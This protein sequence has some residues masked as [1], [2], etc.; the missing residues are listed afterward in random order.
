[1]TREGRVSSQDQ[2]INSNGQGSS[3]IILV[4]QLSSLN[5]LLKGLV[6]LPFMN[7]F[8][9]DL[10]EVKV[11][12]RYF[13]SSSTSFSKWINQTIPIE[14]DN[15]LDRPIVRI[16][17]VTT[18]NGE[19][20]INANEGKQKVFFVKEDHKITFEGISFFHHDSF[21]SASSGGGFPS[22]SSLNNSFYPNYNAIDYD[23]D[24]KKQINDS[25]LQVRITAKHGQ[26]MLL[27]TTNLLIL[28]EVTSKESIP[29]IS[30][31]SSNNPLNYLYHVNPLSF[32]EPAWRNSVSSQAIP[33]SLPDAFT[34]S[35]LPTVIGTPYLKLQ[36]FTEKGCDL[37]RLSSVKHFS[38]NTCV[39]YRRSDDN[40]LHSSSGTNNQV[41]ALFVISKIE[42]ISSNSFSKRDY[43]YNT[44]TCSVSSYLGQAA[45]ILPYQQ[46]FQ[47]KRG[48]NSYGFL[49]I[50]GINSEDDLTR[51]TFTD[52][53]Q[54]LWRKE[55]LLQGSLF[56]LNHAISLLTY[57]PNLNWNSRYNRYDT[58]ADSK[59]GEKQSVAYTLFCQFNNQSEYCLSSSTATVRDQ[60]DEL[61]IDIRTA[62]ST[63][64]ELGLGL[65]LN[66]SASLFIYVEAVNDNPV[67]TMPAQEIYNELGLVTEDQLSLVVEKIVPFVTNED[68]L[69]FLP[70]LVIRD[71]DFFDFGFLAV[72]ITVHH[73]GILFTKNSSEIFSSLFDYLSQTNLQYL[74]D[75]TS[76]SFRGIKQHGL[77]S[78][79]FIGRIN[80]I[81][82][83]FSSMFFLPEENYW[84]LNG[85]IYITI[86]DL[87]NYGL[88]VYDQGKY[89]LGKGKKDSIIIPFIIHPVNDNPTVITPAENSGK[90]IFLLDEGSIL[91]L[92]G[93]SHSLVP[94]TTIQMLNSAKANAFKSGYEV[95]RL[96]EPKNAKSEAT[97][98][99]APNSSMEF[100]YGNG[101]LD[102]NLN[103]ISDINAGPSS[104][105]P[106]FY[107]VYRNSM[108]YQAND[109]LHGAELWRD[110]GILEYDN[111]ID[112]FPL[113]PHSLPN[114]GKTASQLF[115]DLFPG[116]EASSPSYL[117]VH[118]DILY[119]SAN[120]I[121]TSWMVLPEHR[122]TCS[123]FRQS[124]FDSRIFYGV[125][126]NTLWQPGR[127]Y[128]CPKGYRWMSTD[129]A[130]ELFTLNLQ[131]GSNRLWHSEAFSSKNHER[132]GNQYYDFRTL[133]TA[134]SVE[135]DHYEKVYFSQCGWNG[136]KYWNESRIHFRFSD[137]HL[138][139]AYKHTASPDPFHPDYDSSTSMNSRKSL[140][141]DE[142]A[143]IVCVVD[144]WQPLKEV[145]ASTAS[146][147]ALKNK[148]AKKN[149]VPLAASDPA[150]LAAP[151]YLLDRSSVGHELW[152]SDGSLEGT[153][154][155]SDIYPGSQS[156]SPAYLTSFVDGYLYFAATDNEEGRELWRSKG[157]INDAEIVSSDYQSI[158]MSKGG[159]K[160]G[161][162]GR[163]KENRNGIYPGPQSSSPSDIIVVERSLVFAATDFYHGREVVLYS[164][165]YALPTPTGINNNFPGYSTKDI[166]SGFD[167]S[168]PNGFAATLDS[169]NNP[170]FPV[171][172]QARNNTIGAE[173]WILS[174]IDAQPSLVMNICPGSGSSNPRY[175]TYYRQKTLFLFQADDCFFGT[176]LWRSDGTT[177]GTY[178]LKDISPGTF[179]S[180]PSYLTIMTSTLDSLKDFLYFSANDRSQMSSFRS[181][182]LDGRVTDHDV[183]NEI[184][185]WRTDGTTE[186]T[187]RA[188]DRSGNDFSLDRSSLD[189]AFPAKFGIF[190]KNQ[191]YVSASYGDYDT[192]LPSGG[193]NFSSSM[194]TSSDFPLSAYDR[195]Q[196]A[197]LDDIDTS[198]L[199]KNYTMT[200]SVDKGILILRDNDFASSTNI[201]SPFGRRNSPVSLKIL[202]LEIKTIDRIY[203]MNSLV[204]LGHSVD[205]FEESDLAI[206]AIQQAYHLSQTKTPSAIDR[207]RP[208]DALIVGL[209]IGNDG[210][211]GQYDGFQV[212]RLIRFW[213]SSILLNNPSYSMISIIAMSKQFEVLND[214]SE[215]LAAGADLFILQPSTEYQNSTSFV[216][217]NAAASSIPPSPS[218]LVINNENKRISFELYEK[219]IQQQDYLKL[220][221]YVSSFLSH[222]YQ[223]LNITTFI[224]PF[225][226][227]AINTLSS[228]SPLFP[229]NI[230]GYKMI[231]QGN[232]TILND[233]LMNIFFYS[234]NGTNAVEDIN[235][236]I[237]VSDDTTPR[238]PSINPYELMKN[239]SATSLP[240]S[241]DENV[242]G[243]NMMPYL[244][245]Y[246]DANGRI[247]NSSSSTFSA[248]SDSF[249]SASVSRPFIL[250]TTA[251]G[252]HNIYYHHR[253]VV[254]Y[255]KDS[256]LNASTFGKYQN[257]VEEDYERVPSTK[258]I[259]PI[260]VM[261]VNQ[262]P[263]LQLLDYPSV[264]VTS[265]YPPSPNNPNP[266][267]YI[268]FKSTLDEGR[269]LPAMILSDDDI[270]R[271]SLFN[272]YGRSIQPSFYFSIEAF[273]GRLT[274]FSELAIGIK[275][276]IGTSNNDRK[277]VFQGPLDLLQKTFHSSSFAVPPTISVLSSSSS[278]SSFSSSN[279]SAFQYVCRSIDGCQEGF[280]DIITIELNDLGIYGKGG[281]ISTIIHLHMNITGIVHSLP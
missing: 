74:S 192:L 17:N 191:L 280:I 167:S 14:V 83:L 245:D 218:F 97:K 71:V 59:E 230:F 262:P 44:S 67:I 253:N 76:S 198:P 146:M 150:M 85:R 39:R 66:D 107:T 55:I 165:P 27:T 166:V 263:V 18:S 69:L 45:V 35:E 204:A 68:E 275:Q 231:L 135:N 151:S 141:V 118:N 188:F 194:N 121:D 186:G 160:E 178:M 152:R 271:I 232:L 249:S 88:G 28:N 112:L 91:H 182:S 65:G 33:S 261:A 193:L 220:G 219:E 41:N 278:S 20:M 233:V 156:S 177:A 256:F 62:E 103:T 237:E 61:I 184:Q 273:Y 257:C 234:P 87:G 36:I 125:T 24:M 108:Y 106:R 183:M 113:Y 95:W 70:P 216:G 25:I 21:L 133:D 164:Y 122:D 222:F 149:V 12:D 77:S 163:E 181:R 92:L 236:T 258:K 279:M 26:F 42:S 7:Y 64:P 229:G 172:F 158:G 268:S 196:L 179:G 139:G 180:F 148:K 29:D 6:Y 176:E 199:A 63:L 109:G 5:K 49:S 19:Y 195:R 58:R 174:S 243:N 84:G 115:L 211:S 120:G 187:Q 252:N 189:S 226:E 9:E 132:Q 138:T 212:I 239:F 2:L 197:I 201:H 208:Y 10:L 13:T 255:I 248:S 11:Q 171:L 266:P 242:A 221:R 246:L 276:S 136:V 144:S 34:S 241:H 15:V 265:S 80:I 238:C 123:S 117:T 214:E 31:T 40:S 73:G 272:E 142:F 124:S 48:D 128:D 98:S 264:N 104:S 56:D 75:Q 147:K 53:H 60:Y 116:S 90:E 111:H 145:N 227:F 94:N 119:F 43:Y 143:G 137:S 170:I 131:S 277:M 105:H 101:R 72:N 223:V 130:N 127:V 207:S 215:S 200:L 224:E 205:V 209:K 153:Y 37:R 225:Q 281:P 213:E 82:E 260:Y 162:V 244:V 23:E 22:Y 206:D 270:R 159:R 79:T 140:K 102:W 96:V 93:T 217:G 100:S 259:I 267:S 52:Y 89:G 155:L 169:S 168:F 185:L 1:M 240:L 202:I 51:N 157:G 86:N 30:L 154:R 81:N 114:Y 4:G 50:E 46:C 173:L 99:K 175:L 274:L 38:L 161:D 247:R 203:L 235:L 47:L 8:G 16:E 254:Q 190:Q 54:Q 129:E 3:S 134:T 110:N 32:P 228:K 210:T 251:T 57:Q 126:N 78:L 269:M 250:S